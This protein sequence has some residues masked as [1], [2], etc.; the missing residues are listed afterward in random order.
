M[1][2]TTSASSTRCHSGK[3]AKDDNVLPKIIRPPSQ[4]IPICYI[5]EQTMDGTHFHLPPFGSE[6]PFCLGATHPHAYTHVYAHS[7]AHTD[8]RIGGN[9]ADHGPQLVQR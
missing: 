1:S 5:H 2:P 6:S 7:D 4:I 3:E 8:L 9:T